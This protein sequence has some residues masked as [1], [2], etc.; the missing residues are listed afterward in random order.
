MIKASLNDLQKLKKLCPK[1]HLIIATS[2][3]SGFKDILGILAT[4]LANVIQKIFNPKYN[5]WKKYI[6]HM[7]MIYYKNNEL[8]IGEMD[9]KDHW[10]ENLII[11]SNSFQKLKNGEIRIFDL[12]KIPEN[13]FTDFVSYAKGVKYPFWGALSSYILFGIFKIFRTKKSFKEKRYCSEIF[14]RYQPF[15]KYFKTT[16]KQL[17]R[18]YKTHHPEAIDYYL[19]KNFNLKILKVKKGKLCI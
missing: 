4:F 9:F 3:Y 11:N 16:G 5:N 2:T 7:F 18:K 10:K 13:E 19:C 1:D 6:A 17:L 15:F 8:W 12:G 14:V